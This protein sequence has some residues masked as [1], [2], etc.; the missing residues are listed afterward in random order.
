MFLLNDTLKAAFP[1]DVVVNLTLYLFRYDDLF[2]KRKD[3]LNV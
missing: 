3:A 2:L 1:F